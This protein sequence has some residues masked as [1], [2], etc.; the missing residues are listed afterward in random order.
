MMRE[1][2]LSE[3]AISVK[4]GAGASD[5]RPIPVRL[6]FVATMY[7]VH[8]TAEQTRTSSRKLSKVIRR[9]NFERLDVVSRDHPYPQLQHYKKSPLLI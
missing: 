8:W 9:C 5:R 4:L 2:G 1:R 7:R 6:R 3:K